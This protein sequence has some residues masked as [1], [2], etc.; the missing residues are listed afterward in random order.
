MRY[1]LIALLSISSL[2]SHAQQRG[3]IKSYTLVQ[4]LT[5]DSFGI[6][7]EQY[8]G[9]PGA[10]LGLQYDFAVYKV[11]YYTLDYY[12]DS[13]T[14]A[15][16]LVTLPIGYPCASGI[17]TFGHG[18]CL[19]DYEV[20][21]NPGSIY[22]MIVKGIASNGYVG[23]APDYIHLGPDASP[24][25][26][27]FM[28]AK[29]EGAATV[30]LIRAAKTICQNEGIALT[31]Q[32]FL[33][34]YSQGGHSSF[35]TAREIQLHHAGE[36]T[37]TAV[38]P[39]GGTFDLA[40]VAADSLSSNTRITPEPH[41]FCMIVRSYSEVYQ[42]S[43]FIMGLPNNPADAF[44]SIF[45]HP[46]DSLLA[47]ILDRNNPFA[48]VNLLD[49]IPIRMVTDSFRIKFQTDA[50]FYFR[51]L[52]RYNS[53]YDWTP[54]MPVN[55]VHSPVDIENP[56]SNVQRVM[57]LFLDS[58]ATDV[59]LTLIGGNLSH[60]AAGL[61]YVLF[62][63]D[64]MRNKRVDCLTGVNENIGGN[65]EWSIYPNPVMDELHINWQKTSLDVQVTLFS[66]TGRIIHSQMV[67]GASQMFRLPVTTLPAGHYAV[68]V[69]T[70][71]NRYYR[72]MV[73]L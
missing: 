43:L 61:P 33:S 46:Y 48:S 32:L 67:A 57:Q 65:L 27:A 23:V 13:L 45:K 14:I 6:E 52:L 44:D 8:T 70:G 62:A 40:G 19:K 73:K 54:R 17:F 49:S 35:A 24:G 31:D 47:M 4:T 42:D 72:V 50:N 41:A 12:P 9:F 2:F 18:F 69:R 26:Q 15:T 59:Q 60:G 28:N 5:A 29:T 53:L 1:A 37:V 58:G 55:F 38:C 3:E 11:Q 39:G 63:M 51:T 68:E 64:Y 71:N 22:G 10:V 16:G 56:M 20:P 30:D 25:F 7:V 21:S 66:A 34:G 36:F